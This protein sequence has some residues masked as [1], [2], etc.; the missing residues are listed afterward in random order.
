MALALVDTAD[1][2]LSLVGWLRFAT[3]WSSVLESS[4]GAACY[5]ESMCD[6]R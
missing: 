6:A 4:R 2:G 5:R 3:R 1:I